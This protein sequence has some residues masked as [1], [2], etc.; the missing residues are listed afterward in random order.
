MAEM[1]M[2][3]FERKM[4]LVDQFVTNIVA[5]EGF[6]I[7]K[8]VFL[9]EHPASSNEGHQEKDQFANKN[10][11]N[12]ENPASTN[13]DHNEQDQATE[14]ENHPTPNEIIP[15]ENAA[16]I[17]S[18]EETINLESVSLP[19][20]NRKRGRPKGTTKSAI[21]LPRKKRCTEVL[22]KLT[23]KRVDGNSWATTS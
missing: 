3:M 8:D 15:E 10:Q 14:E 11:P 7:V 5:G 12:D 20:R 16:D 6:Q 19:T 4:T 13:E 9:D 1:R 2:E 17:A 18:S 23:L 22:T 21:G